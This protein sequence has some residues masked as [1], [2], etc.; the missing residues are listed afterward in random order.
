ME[1]KEVNTK[2]MLVTAILVLI[3]LLLLNYFLA[4]ANINEVWDYKNIESISDVIMYGQRIE[5]RTIYYNL[6][7]IVTKYLNSYKNFDTIIEDTEDEKVLYQDYYKHLTKDYKKHLS[8]KEYI[9][10]A[11]KFLEKFYVDS[12]SSQEAMDFIAFM[13]TEQVLKEVYAYE[14]NV[15]LCELESKYTNEKGYIAVQ[16]DTNLSAFYIV[17]IQ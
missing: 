12:T 10:V 4:N 17:Y 13:D 7:A 15:Y 9:K 1:N 8:K 3:V 14:D 2:L 5:D 16:I 6:E 11:K